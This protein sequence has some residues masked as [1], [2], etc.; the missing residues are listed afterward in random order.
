MTVPPSRLILPTLDDYGLDPS[1]H[2]HGGCASSSH[3]LYLGRGWVSDMNRQS[4]KTALRLAEPWIGGRAMDFG[5]TDGI[6]PPSLSR[7]FRH[8]TA[9]DAE[10]Q[11][12]QLASRLVR[13]MHLD[14]VR[15]LCNRGANLTDLTKG[16]RY[17]VIFCLE[18][19]EYVGTVQDM[20][21]SKV[22][23]LRKLLSLLAPGGAMII[24][25]PKMVGP[26]FLL[27]Y[28]AQTVLRRHHE[29]L[30]IWELIA[31]GLSLNTDPV[32]LRWTGRHLGFNH[33]KLRRAIQGEFR[34]ERQ[35]SLGA[36]VI[37]V[38]RR[39]ADGAA[40]RL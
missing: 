11:F 24:S 17:D 4:F 5:C 32:E 10:P 40:D 23:M 14:N 30:S 3:Y 35:I 15:L 39:P 7:Q 16:Q 36:T 18:T 25:V 21:G 6:L 38:I 28:V 26:A 12:I 9:I 22:R 37:W 29:R 34:I 13:R 20:Y 27:K 2:H 8:A 31:S 1:A 33:Y 19:L